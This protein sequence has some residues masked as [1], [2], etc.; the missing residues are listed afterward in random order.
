ML[1]VGLVGSLGVTD[2]RLKVV[3]LVL[4]EVSDTGKVGPLGVGV[5][6]HLDDTVDNGLSDLVLG[7]SGSTVED[8]VAYASA[9]SQLEIPSHKK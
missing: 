2:L 5:D 1:L 9:K 7:R 3:L 4:D 8:K 6:V